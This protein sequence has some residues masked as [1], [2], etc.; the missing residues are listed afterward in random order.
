MRYGITKNG[1]L[2][3]LL[4]SAFVLGAFTSGELLQKITRQ[5]VK[6]AANIMGLEMT[7]PEID[8]LLPNLEEFREAYT[9]NREKQLD[10]GLVPSLTFNPVPDNYIAALGKR[11]R[12]SFKNPG[13]SILPEDKDKLAW[14]SIQELASLIKNKEITS[15]ELTKVFINRL[16]KYDEQLNCVVTLTEDLAMEQAKKADAEIAKGNYKGLLHGIPYGIKDL[17]ATSMHKTTWGAAPFKDQKL[18]FDATVV[19]KLDEAGAVMVAKLSLGAL[20]MGDKWFDGMTRNPWKPETGSSGSSAGSAAAVAAGLVPFAIGTETLGSIV[21]PSTVC[22]TA[23]LRPTFGRVSRH[24][25]MALCWSMD[26]VGPI[27][28]TAEETAVV[29]NE[30]YGL[31]EKDPTTVDA[32]FQYAP[33][34]YQNLKVG[35]VKSDFEKD[36]PFK[37]QDST[38]LRKLKAMGVELIPIELPEFPDIS[39]ILYAEAAAAFDDL[40][41]SNQDDQLTQQGKNAWPNIFRSARFIPA[42]EYIKANRLRTKLIAD[43][44]EVFKKVDVYV[45]PSWA[46]QSLRITNYTGHPCVVVPNGFQEDG[47]PTSITFTGNW[48]KEGEIVSLAQAYQTQTGFYLK[49]P[50]LDK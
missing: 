34:M 22:G 7:N 6:G 12:T 3:L 36:Y 35:Y 37:S 4:I 42:V 43:M 8:S 5:D 44:Q 18:D 39:S 9:K 23:G 25:A 38:T 11:S 33:N 20:A 45:H 27:C 17:F 26:K 13:K 14:Y 21:S 32:P 1:W 48:F 10:N 47:R 49:H 40:T 15:V 50:E 29:F 2:A 41:T 31:D 30:I 16:K 19:K 46:S 24:G 28:K